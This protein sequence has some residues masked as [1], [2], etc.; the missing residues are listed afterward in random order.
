[1][2]KINE[3]IDDS[4]NIV[5]NSNGEKIMKFKFAQRIGYTHKWLWDR[6]FPQCNHSGALLLFIFQSRFILKSC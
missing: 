3:E 6:V 1:M 5:K 4:D 2:G